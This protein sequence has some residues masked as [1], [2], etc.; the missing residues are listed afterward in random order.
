MKFIR[1]YTLALVVASF[2]LSSSHVSG[3]ER[4]QNVIDRIANSPAWTSFCIFLMNTGQDVASCK[5]YRGHSF[6]DSLTKRPIHQLHTLDRTQ[7]AMLVFLTYLQLS[8][9]TIS[10]RSPRLVGLNAFE[11]NEHKQIFDEDSYDL[12]HPQPDGTM[13]CCVIHDN[14]LIT[15]CRFD[16]QADRIGHIV[17]SDIVLEEQSALQATYE[18]GPDNK[19]IINDHNQQNALILQSDSNALSEC[20]L[21]NELSQIAELDPSMLNPLNWALE[22]KV[23]LDLD[24]YPR[25]Q[26]H[27]NQVH[28]ILHITNNVSLCIMQGS[29]FSAY[30][31]RDTNVICF[32]T[33][34]F[35]QPNAIFLGVLGHEMGHAKQSTNSFQQRL[36][37]FNREALTIVDDEPCFATQTISSSCIRRFNLEINADIYAVLINKNALGL[38]QGILHKY[39]PSAYSE[40]TKIPHTSNCTFE[41]DNYYDHP[42]ALTCRIPLM[43]LLG[44]KYQELSRNLEER[45]ESFQNS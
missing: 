21:Q 12:C 27:L 35:K 19:I 44:E 38:A 36:F 25:L 24:H 33:E 18:I 37:A 31:S 43:L 6:D 2:A 23:Y 22:K 28:D 16:L 4:V 41:R 5:S 26:E 20:I 29:T 10:M 39:V 34:V 15:C 11:T 17:C 3:M 7:R 45:M 13:Q 40:Q 32:S 42:D 1:K 9:R 8:A 14:R 30:Y